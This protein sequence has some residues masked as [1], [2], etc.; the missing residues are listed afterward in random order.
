KHISS[1][2]VIADH[3]RATTFLIGE[4]ILPAN[5][6]RAYVLRRVMRRAIVHGRKLGLEGPFLGEIA[7]VVMDIMGDIY[8]EIIQRRD[9]ILKAIQ[10]E[11][12]S[13]QRTLMSGLDRFDQVSATLNLQPGGTFPA[14]EMFRLYDTYGHS[15]DLIKDLA[16]ARGF[17]TDEQAYE[18][19]MSRQREQSKASSKFGP[20]VKENVDIYQQ[21]SPQP[22]RFLGYDYSTLDDPK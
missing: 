10:T 22:T 1:Y 14:D 2:R 5:E 21:V 11:E 19:A 6:G 9:F 20:A 18:R 15:K 13:F 3:S 12:E 4:G 16:V 8:P 7:K 17:Q